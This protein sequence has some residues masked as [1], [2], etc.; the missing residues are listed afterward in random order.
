[1]DFTKADQVAKRLV[2]NLFLDHAKI[3]EQPHTIRRFLGAATPI[4]PIDFIDN[5]TDGLTNRYFL[6]GRAGT[7]KST[8]LR[9]VVAEAKQRGFDSEIYHC[10]FDPE[11]LDMVIVRELGWAVFDSTSPH[12]YFP[13]RDGDEVIDMYELT[14]A[15]DTDEM[16]AK[17]IAEIEAQYRREMKDGKRYLNDA[18]IYG[19]RLE[20]IYQ[21]VSNSSYLDGI[22]ID[23]NNEIKLLAND[24]QPF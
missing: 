2:E 9:K 17:E 16:F 14:V 15:P 6:K 10:G 4:G 3:N 23:I 7:G 1:M 22:F 11:S 8:I 5:I 12:E 18:R 13:E 21:S 24:G 20:K 19:N